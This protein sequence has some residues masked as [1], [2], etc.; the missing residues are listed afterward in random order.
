M[1]IK[2]ENIFFTDINI[3]NFF[4]CFWYNVRTTSSNLFIKEL[5]EY[6]Y[7]RLIIIKIII[8]VKMG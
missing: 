4:N 6:I 3:I 1:E 2:K 7:K 8:F 5:Y